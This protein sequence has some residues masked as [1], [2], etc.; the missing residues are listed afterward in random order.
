MQRKGQHVNFKCQSAEQDQQLY[1][2]GK[3]SCLHY[4]PSIKDTTQLSWLE[5][6]LQ[7]AVVN[8]GIAV[9]ATTLLLSICYLFYRT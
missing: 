6:S 1:E 7:N 9:V 8:I 2:Q 5:C 4:S 3:A